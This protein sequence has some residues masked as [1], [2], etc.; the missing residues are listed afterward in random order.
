GRLCGCENCF[1]ELAG[2]VD[3]KCREH[4]QSRK[5]QRPVGDRK[6]ELLQRSIDASWAIVRLGTTDRYRKQRALSRQNAVAVAVRIA[7]VFVPIGK[8]VGEHAIEPA[9]EGGWKCE[10]PDRKWKDNRV[11]R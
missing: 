10:A 7:G 11:G 2:T 8:F 4:I 1:A 9:L 6:Q 5:K 3:H